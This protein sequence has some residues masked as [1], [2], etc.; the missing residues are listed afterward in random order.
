MSRYLEDPLYLLLFLLPAAGWLFAFYPIH[1]LI[2]LHLGLCVWILGRASYYYY[3]YG[4]RRELLVDPTVLAPVSRRI[5]ALLADIALLALVPIFVPLQHILSNWYS[6]AI[7]LLIVAAICWLGGTPGKWTVPLAIV[8]ATTGRRATLWQTFLRMVGYCI[9]AAPLGLGF[10]WA[11]WDHSG[12]TWHDM[13]SGTVVVT[14]TISIDGD[15]GDVPSD[16]TPQPQ[17]FT[18]RTRSAPTFGKR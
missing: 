16:T 6:V 11:F 18:P 12:R 17:S 10:L 2:T 8:D 7:N 13:L 5:Y 3:L 15:H 1:L 9:S 4:V 14:P